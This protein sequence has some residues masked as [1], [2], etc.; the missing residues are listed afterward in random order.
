MHVDDHVTALI[1]IANSSKFSNHYNIGGGNQIKNIDLVEVICERMDH[2]F[3]SKLGPSFKTHLDL[4]EFVDDR[5]GHDRRYDIDCSKI[6]KELS[7][8]PKIKFETGL[9]ETIDW[10][11]D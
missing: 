8:S 6:K 4:I 3:P 5:P 10:Y 7:W 9:L 11:V 1:K 2:L